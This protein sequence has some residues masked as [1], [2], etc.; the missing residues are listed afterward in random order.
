MS[1]TVS[2]RLHHR[3]SR[4]AALLQHGIERLRARIARRRAIRELDRL[5]D[6]TLLDVGLE[7]CDIAARVDAGTNDVTMLTL[8]R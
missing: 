5:S 4:F 1:A 3:E 6:Q 8:R 2:N 7:R